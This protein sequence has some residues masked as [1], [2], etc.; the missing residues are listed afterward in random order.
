MPV[1][2]TRAPAPKPP[3]APAVRFGFYQ[4]GHFAGQAASRRD[5]GTLWSAASARGSDNNPLWYKC[6]DAFAGI[7]LLVVL[8]AS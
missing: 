3:I 4:L 5:R 7:G 6:K 8:V 2:R 1:R